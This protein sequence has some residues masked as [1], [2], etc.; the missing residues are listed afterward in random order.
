V[1]LN[2]LSSDTLEAVLVQE[3]K[4]DD[5]LS[6]WIDPRLA[7]RL[8]A[9]GVHTPREAIER[10]NA[11]GPRWTEGVQWF[12]AAAAARVIN[13]LQA[14]EDALGLAIENIA[15]VPRRDLVAAWKGA[16]QKTDKIVREGS[17]PAR[18][19]QL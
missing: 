7:G 18:W 3:P 2:D 17:V 1:R 5:P 13:W 14:N 16:P 19:S 4:A 9:A 15:L 11:K 12:G 10:I 6:S 8:A